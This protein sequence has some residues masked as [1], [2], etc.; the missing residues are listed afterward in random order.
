MYALESHCNLVLVSYKVV[1]L[2]LTPEIEVFYMLFDRSLSIFSITSLKHHMEYFNFQCKIQLRLAV[3]KKVLH[4]FPVGCRGNF[5]TFHTTQCNCQT[6]CASP[7]LIKVN[8]S[9][10]CSAIRV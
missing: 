7:D 6:F 5:N 2:N 8:F 3:Q 9:R 10:A 4:L 1:Q